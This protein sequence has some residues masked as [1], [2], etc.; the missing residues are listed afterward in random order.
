MEKK[1][2]VIVPVFNVEDYLKACL[3]SISNQT[4][5]NIEIIVVDDGATDNSGD[6]ADQYAKEDQRVKVLHQLNGGLSAA[7]NTG[8][9][10]ASG[11]YVCFIDSD[12]W[13]E[14]DYLEILLEALL[15][16]EADIA[17]LKMKKIQD[18]HQ[19]TNLTE[20]KNQW[21]L[22]D[23]QVAMK[24]LFMNNKIGY[25]SN[26][27]LFRSE[28]FLN[29]RFPVGRLMEDMATTYLLIDRSQLVVVNQ[30]EKYH[31]FQSPNSI[32]RGSFNPKRLELFDIQN[33]IIQ[34][35]D[36]KYPDVSVKVRTRTVYAAIRMIMAMI[37]NQYSN[38]K[39][40]DY[41]LAFI[42]KYQDCLNEDPDFSKKLKYL[43]KF[44][45]NHPN[46]IFSFTRKKIIGNFLSK[47]EMMR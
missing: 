35:I 5:Q 32:L 26:N 39:N 10:Y 8:L 28:L 23:R 27:K 41:V 21:E 16:F 47:I 22:M 2:S 33:E 7:R 18:Y 44:I 46:M 38:R 37:E 31:Y 11:E 30:S 34:F 20:N 45:A 24:N 42:E 1:I 29:L 40:F 15:K 17:V 4:V 19:I 13:I 9:D 6:I 3:L 25:S 14:P 43:A 36:E 12:D